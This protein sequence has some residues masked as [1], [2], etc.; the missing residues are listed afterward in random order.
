[1]GQQAPGQGMT[2]PLCMESAS[3]TWPGISFAPGAVTFDE[4]VDAVREQVGRDVVLVISPPE[5]TSSL[6][7][8]RGRL[9]FVEEQSGSDRAVFAVEHPHDARWAGPTGTGFALD[10]GA[11]T[12]G[13]RCGGPGQPGISCLQDVVRISIYPELP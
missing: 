11:Y 2:Q 6:R 12:S 4:L 13:E 9:R 8:F 1:M 10:R 3:E 7:P 5:W